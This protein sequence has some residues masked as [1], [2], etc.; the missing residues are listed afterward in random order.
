MGTMKREI[1]SFRAT[2][3]P[4]DKKTGNGKTTG[5]DGGIGFM[6]KGQVARGMMGG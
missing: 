3:N 5:D 2:G 6:Q 4:L 1:V